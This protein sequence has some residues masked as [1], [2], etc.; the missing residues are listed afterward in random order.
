VGTLCWP[1]WGQ[2]RTGSQCVEQSGRM[3]FQHIEWQ[4][5]YNKP[6]EDPKN[7]AN[8]PGSGVNTGA[9]TPA[10]TLGVFTGFVVGALPLR[11]LSFSLCIQAGGV[12][13]LWEP[14]AGTPAPQS[15]P[16]KTV[17]R[18][19]GGETWTDPTLLEWELAW[20]LGSSLGLL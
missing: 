16:Q 8:H 14:P 12:A 2:V 18:S 3:C 11:N 9:G 17:V 7:Q 4:S 1:G 10:G 19:G 13:T 6:S 5:A 20:F 15:Q